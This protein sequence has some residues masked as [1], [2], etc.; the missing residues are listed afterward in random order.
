MNDLQERAI[1]AAKAFC[2]RRGYDIIDSEWETEDGTGIDLV[3][4]DEDVL[5]FVD[6]LSRDG[7]AKGLPA[8]STGSRERC[9]RAAAIWLSQHADDEEFVDVTVR[10]DVISILTLSENKAFL[11]HHINALGSNT[12]FADSA[13]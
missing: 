3:A 5:V 6:V 11:K 7:A 13:D 9:E 12:S 1:K 10:F 8:E 4:R 2:T